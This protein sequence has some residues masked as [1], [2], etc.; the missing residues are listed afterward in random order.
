MSSSLKFLASTALCFVMAFTVVGC[1]EKS[2]SEEAAPA[3]DN[4]EPSEEPDY[5]SV[6]HI[7][8]AFEGSVPGKQITRTSAEAEA[9]AGDILVR[10]R[11]GEDFGVL[12]EEYTDD[13]APGIYKMANFGVSVNAGQQ[14]Y[15]RQGMVPAFGDVGFPLQVGEIGLAEYDPQKSPFGWHIIKRVE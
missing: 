3:T 15:Q 12:V 1:G 2:E 13:S 14:V 8:I 9:L 10:A 7:L 11:E 4:T 6:Q 5:I